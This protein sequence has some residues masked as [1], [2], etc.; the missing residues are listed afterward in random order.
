MR[1][2]NSSTL[3]AL[4][5]IY[6][7]QIV[8][9][10]WHLQLFVWLVIKVHHINIYMQTMQQPQLLKLV[11][12]HVLLVCTLIN[13]KLCYVLIVYPLVIHVLH[14]PYVLLVFQGHIYSIIHAQQHVLLDTTL[15]T[16]LQITVMHVVPVV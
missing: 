11:N 4:P 14:P 9:L 6:V 12:Y 7:I 3:S 8:W 16:R 13:H 2:A 15:L 10:V 5:V 1:Q